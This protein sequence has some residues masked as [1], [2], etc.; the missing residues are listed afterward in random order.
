MK[1]VAL[2][3]S[4]TL[5]MS[6]AVVALAGG[7]D[8]PEAKQQNQ[9]MYIGA[10]WLPGQEI[11]GNNQTTSQFEPAAGGLNIGYLFN[12]YFGVEAGV[13]G[14]TQSNSINETIF[15][16]NVNDSASVSM[17]AG[18]VAAKGVLPLGDSFDLYG[19]LGVGSFAMYYD[20]TLSDNSGTVTAS[21]NK[22]EAAPMFAAGV[23]FYPANH[24]E[25]SLEQSIYYLHDEQV[26][27]GFTGAGVTYHF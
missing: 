21:A 17:I 24:V 27:F 26:G 18:Y 1:K 20:E 4:S 7:P 13:Q 10:Q 14:Y 12:R 8:M 16:D 11:L 25:I 22:T 15:G 2:L 9:G 19:K 3:L 6:G 5:L 23:G